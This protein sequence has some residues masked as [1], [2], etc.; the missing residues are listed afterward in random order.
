MS[1]RNPT[2][3][4]AD[5]ALHRMASIY[6]SRY[7]GIEDL[8]EAGKPVQMK[9]KSV[10]TEML[11]S[12]MLGRRK[13]NGGEKGIVVFER[14]AGKKC[15]LILNKTS[16]RALKKAWGEDASKWIG[17]TVSVELGTVNGKEACL[18]TPVIGKS[19]PDQLPPR[20]QESS[21][22]GG[23]GHVPADNLDFPE[24]LIPKDV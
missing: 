18:V 22:S 6:Q 20:G 12:I 1:Y 8:R 10:G 14:P 16:F 11:E 3:K 19:K 5:D 17:S 21:V 24:D 13:L 7:I 9:I 15:E 4:N 2:S 23:L